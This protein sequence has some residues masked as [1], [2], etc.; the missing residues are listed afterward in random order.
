MKKILLLATLCLPLLFGGC[1]KRVVSNTISVYGFVYD[2]E[3]HEPISGVHLTLSPSGKNTDTGEDGYY[4]FNN[5]QFNHDKIVISAQKSG[6][7]TTSRT[8]TLPKNGES[9]INFNMKK[10]DK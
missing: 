3:T 9:Q 2:Y 8:I 1:V 10:L 6:Y 4:A 5:V 7:E